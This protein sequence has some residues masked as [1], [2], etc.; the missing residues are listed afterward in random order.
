ME[1]EVDVVV[2][3]D[4]EV[5][6]EDDYEEERY[7]VITFQTGW[8]RHHWD[9]LLNMDQSMELVKTRTKSR[10]INKTDLNPCHLFLFIHTHGLTT[11]F[12]LHPSPLLPP[13]PPLYSC[14]KMSNS[15]CLP[16]VYGYR[17]HLRC[18]CWRWYYTQPWSE[19]TSLQ[20]ASPSQSPP[21]GWGGGL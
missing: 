16:P 3:V 14:E 17:C 13:T 1:A 15:C 10:A 8:Q 12:N 6:T 5:W 2:E 7:R 20:G 11:A 4:V 18:W 19:L 21:T 9:K